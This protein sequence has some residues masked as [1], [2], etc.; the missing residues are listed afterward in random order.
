MLF[1][2][3]FPYRLSFALPENPHF[4]F[5]MCFLFITAWDLLISLYILFFFVY[6][7]LEDMY[8][9]LFPMHIILYSIKDVIV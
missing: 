7:Y 4:M 5:S 9:F 6:T 2:L 8:L 3:L 1:K